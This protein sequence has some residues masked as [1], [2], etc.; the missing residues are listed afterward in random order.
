[1]NRIIFDKTV[2][3][4]AQTFA[5]VTIPEPVQSVVPL[6]GQNSYHI[7]FLLPPM[8]QGQK[9]SFVNSPMDI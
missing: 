8:K 2:Q 6:K 3:E 7:F 5:F 1:M 4:D 9:N